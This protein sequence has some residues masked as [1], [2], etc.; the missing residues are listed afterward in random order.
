MD[1]LPARLSDPQQL[2]GFIFVHFNICLYLLY[3][4]IP[5]FICYMLKKRRPELLLMTT[6]LIF[7]QLQHNITLL[8]KK[9]RQELLLN[10][11][12]QM[13]FLQHHITLLQ[14]KQ[15]VLSLCLYVNLTSGC[16]SKFFNFRTTGG[17]FAMVC[18]GRRRGSC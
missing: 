15:K 17:L 11:T 10:T 12:H 2:T 13:I 14:K 16:N 8:Q 18:P 3:L 7:L 4:F 9:H 1:P 5:H 6:R